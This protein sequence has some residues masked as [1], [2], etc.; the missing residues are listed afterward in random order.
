M[1]AIAAALAPDTLVIAGMDLYRHPAGRY[2][3]S[4]AVEG[5]ARGH[6]AECD[7]ALIARALD[8]FKGRVV[9]FSPNLARALGR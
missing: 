8:G 1:I 2:P 5:Y 9:L 3:G 4:D 7:L 6:S